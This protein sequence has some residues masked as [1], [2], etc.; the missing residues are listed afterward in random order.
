[1]TELAKLNGIAL[2]SIAKINGI[3]VAD[4]A[5][6]NGVDIVTAVTN[7]SFVT[8]GVD[9][10]VVFGNVLDEAGSND[11]SAFGWFKCNLSTGVAYLCGKVAGA[12]TQGYLLYCNAAGS[13]GFW[14]CVDST[15][16]WYGNSTGTPAYDD[17]AWHS[18]GVSWDG[19]TKA[20]IVYVDGAAA[21]MGT[22]TKTFG[23]GSASNAG[24]FEI[25]RNAVS[26]ATGAAT[27]GGLI[28]MPFKATPTEFAELHNLKD[29]AWTT[30]SR[31]ADVKDSTRGI[32]ITHEAP[33]DS[34][35][36]GTCYDSKTSNQY[37]GTYTNTE[38]GDRVEDAVA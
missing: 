17:G 14:Y 35:S 23:T 34:T 28:K 38:A 32:L 9:E 2:A 26:G 22:I 11:W 7:Y 19:T 1:M 37:N 29:K 10:R 13:V 27:F 21:T 12:A 24:E 15:H 30:F 5:K 6:I 31:W 20:A 33:S 25:G 36:G 18:L 16:Y 4:C 3:A 8:D